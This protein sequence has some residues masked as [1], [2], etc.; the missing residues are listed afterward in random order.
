MVKFALLGAAALQA[1]VVLGALTSQSLPARDE[2]LRLVKTSEEDAGTWMT[3]EQK[4]EQ[5]IS[6]GIHFADITDT[7]ELETLPR[8]PHGGR[9][10]KAGH[11]PEQ[12]E[13][14][15]RGQPAHLEAVAE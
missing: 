11:V 5:L 7:M 1:T 14:P 8:R 15:V 2:E 13:P 9:R 4:F 10:S 3:E 6:K 12:R